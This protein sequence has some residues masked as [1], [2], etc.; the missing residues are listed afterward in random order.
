MKKIV[1]LIAGFVFS[2][3]VFSQYVGQTNK[4]TSAGAL[5]GSSPLLGYTMAT[6]DFDHKQKELLEG[7]SGSPYTS[8][9]FAPTTLYYK[10]EEVQDIFYR[11]NAYNEEI[12]IKE[13]QGNN[14]A[15][16]ALGKDKSI[17][18]LVDGKPMSFKTFVDKKGSTLNGYLVAL[19]AS[20]K[21]VL[22]KRIN[23]K[24]TEGQ[25]AQNSFVKDIPD[26]FSH[27]TEYY[28][29]QDGGKRLTEIKLKNSQ[30]LKLLPEELRASTKQYMK[31][32]NL[33][34]KN[35]ADLVK[36][37]MHLNS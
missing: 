1:F 31:E 17:A 24:Y 7:I 5:A 8:N 16:R 12:E 13:N 30:L 3:T 36:I 18:I 21:F 25:K 34:I 22:Y 9:N 37:F 28:L 32:N 35:E 14:E 2:T 11:Y 4:L 6:I 26:R 33:N 10:D 20:E 27:F 29:E 15:V 19:Q 23:V